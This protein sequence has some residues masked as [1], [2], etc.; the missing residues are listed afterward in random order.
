MNFNDHKILSS[1]AFRVIYSKTNTYFKLVLAERRRIEIRRKKSE[2]S[3]KKILF[4]RR[5][6]RLLNERCRESSIT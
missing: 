3:K 1:Y 6:S 2:K 5:N 4:W